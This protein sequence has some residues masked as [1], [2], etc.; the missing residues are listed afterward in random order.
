MFFDCP[1]CNGPID[2]DDDLAGTQAKLPTL[3][4]ED[5]YSKSCAEASPSAANFDTMPGLWRQSFCS[6][7]NLPSLRTRLP[8]HFSPCD[9]RWP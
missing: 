6:R 2:A 5:Q 1:K 7:S 3:S 9:E 4:E 8:V